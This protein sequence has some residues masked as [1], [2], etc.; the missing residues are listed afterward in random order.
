[1]KI[2]S[3]SLATLPAFGLAALALVLGV[4]ALANGSVANPAGD[5]PRDADASVVAAESISPVTTGRDWVEVVGT[6]TRKNFR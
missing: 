4:A 5:L 3:K 6:N 2:S 1:V